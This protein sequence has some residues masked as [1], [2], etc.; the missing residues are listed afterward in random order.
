MLQVIGPQ[1]DEEGTED[2]LRGDAGGRVVG[3][4]EHRADVVTVGRQDRVARR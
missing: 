3:D 4:G 1:H 2:L